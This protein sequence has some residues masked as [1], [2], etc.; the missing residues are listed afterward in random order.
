LNECR[1]IHPS[2]HAVD[3]GDVAT[4]E[5]F[6]ATTKSFEQRATVF[7]MSRAHDHCHA[8]AL[9]QPR[10]RSLVAHALSE[11]NGIFDGGFVIG[12][13]EITTSAQGWPEAT[14]MDGNDRLQPGDRINAKVQR[15]QASAL[16][17][18]K[19]RWAPESLL[20]ERQYRPAPENCWS[21]PE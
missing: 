18:R 12:I 5:L 13:G 19:H 9:R 7:H 20:V 6:D 11:A 3:G 8:S 4:V 21:A 14:V 15:F 16:H 17:E 2:R 1:Q 10:Q